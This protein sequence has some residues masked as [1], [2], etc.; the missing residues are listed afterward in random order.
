MFKNLSPSA[1]GI[2]GHQSEIIEL[3]LTFG[4]GGLEL[5]MAEFAGRVKLHGMS[6]ARRLIDSA[7]IQVG[8]FPLPVDWETEDA[9]FQKQLEALAEI[10]AL[11]AEIGCTRCLAMLPAGG[12]RLPYHE[13]FEF[14]KERF[15]AICKALEPS[16]IH[17][18]V[19]FHAA[20]YLR[21]DKE[22]Q[23]IH[24]MDALSLLINMVG[25]PNLGI[26]L[27]VWDLVVGGG[28]IESIGGMSPQQIVAVQV[29]ELPQDVA[30]A[31]LD[32]DSR[33]LPVVENGRIDIAAVLGSL[34]DIGYEGPVAVAPS[35]GIFRT[36]RRDMIARQVAE[37]LDAPWRAAGLPSSLKLQPL[38][39]PPAAKPEGPAESETP[40]EG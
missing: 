32:K 10:A 22:F 31:D 12:D 3:A 33:L 15:T 29:A 21:K 2:S 39:A 8:T 7:N 1:I 24:D 20:E 36:R 17:L 6:Y 27:D 9:D 11:A 30:V 28:S 13:N 37:A 16:G 14:H 4:F 35:Q 26:L 23:F 5:D 40:A 18:G 19:G 34:K 38:P 25:A